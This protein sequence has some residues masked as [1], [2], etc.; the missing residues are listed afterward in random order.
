[1]QGVVQPGLGQP[2]ADPSERVV[3]LGRVEV[4]DFGR[5]ERLAKG[6]LFHRLPR[7]SR[8]ASQILLNRGQRE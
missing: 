6:E 3:V 2:F 8:Q 1:M 7:E 4:T 5:G